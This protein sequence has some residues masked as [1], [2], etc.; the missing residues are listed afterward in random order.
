[1]KMIL[2]DLR[3]AVTNYYYN[4]FYPDYLTMDNLEGNW[5]VYVDLKKL[6]DKMDNYLSF[7]KCKYLPLDHEKNRYSA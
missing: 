1:M 2:R 5:E 6:V 4:M 3:H 7:G